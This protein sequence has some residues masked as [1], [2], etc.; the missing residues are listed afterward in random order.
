[1]NITKNKRK[2]VNANMFVIVVGLRLHAVEHNSLFHSRHN[3]RNRT[4]KVGHEISYGRSGG[5]RAFQS[6]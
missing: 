5:N 6:R 4:G 2:D 3:G 1:V